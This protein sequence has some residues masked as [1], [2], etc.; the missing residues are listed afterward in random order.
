[1]TTVLIA[2]RGEI[3]VRIARA[4]RDLGIRSVA[5]YSSADADALHTRVADEAWA[6]KG[7]TGAQ[8]YM[9]IPALLDIAARVGADCVHPGYGFLSENADFARAVADAGMTWIGPTPET[10]DTLGDKM[11]ARQLAESVG[12]PLAPGTSEPL[13]SWEEAHAFAEEHGLPVVIKAAFGGGGRGLKIVTREDGLDAVEDA[14]LSAGREAGEAFGRTECFVEKFLETPRHVEAQ[15]LADTHGHVSVVGL[16]DCSTQRRF[17]KLVEEAPAPFLTTGQRE[18]ITEGARSICAA[19]GYVGAGTVEFIVAADG[20]VSFLEVNTRVQVEHPVTE[21]TSGVDIVA[22][23]FRI[24]FGEELSWI[25]AGEPLDPASSGHA[26]EFR[27]NAEDVANGFVPCPGT[28]TEFRVPTG[29]GIRVDAGV[30][31]GSTISGFYDSMLGK[32]IVWGPTR[33]IALS[34][35]WAALD[36]FVIS[37]VRTVLPFH[38]DHVRAPEF[39]ALSEEDTVGSADNF[40]VYTDWVDSHYVPGAATGGDIEDAYLERT[41]ISVEIDGRLHRVGIPA[42]VLGAVAGGAGAGAAA[43]ADSAASAA[44]SVSSASGTPVTSPFDGTVVEWKVTDGAQVSKGDTVVAIEAMKM[45]R[46]VTAPADGVL[47]IALGA[48][49][50]AGRG[51]VLGA[52]E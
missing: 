24:A 46:A 38:R 49:E 32:L 40:G 45:E 4:A 14:F 18:Q 52:V 39:T 37:G 35:S 42:G 20:T 30:V 48:G 33:E 25:A 6:L 29:P 13:Q 23:Q 8:T 31:S 16:R 17:Q 15:V 5:V 27:I 2:N 19:A 11:A 26:I 3:A 9:N 22:E 12:A 34:R 21:V 28:V 47:H 7:T 44:S 41:E 36:E 50:H 51:A 10:I 1:M 43:T